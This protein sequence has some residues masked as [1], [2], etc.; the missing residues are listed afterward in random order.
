LRVLGE[1]VRWRGSWSRWRASSLRVLGEEVRSRAPRSE[2]L[3]SGTGAR[4]S[5]S[6]FSSAPSHS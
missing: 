5:R 1:E 3:R 4:G 2:V 6:H